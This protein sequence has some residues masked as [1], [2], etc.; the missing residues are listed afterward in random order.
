MLN[1]VDD[2]NNEYI[3]KIK[4]K[5]HNEYVK[6]VNFLDYLPVEKGHY[7]IDVEKIT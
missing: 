1:L 2:E 6:Y 5:C 3:G 7:S 4:D